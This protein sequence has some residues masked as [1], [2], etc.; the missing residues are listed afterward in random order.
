[1]VLY[2]NFLLQITT[3]ANFR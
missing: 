2:S 1:M 3:P